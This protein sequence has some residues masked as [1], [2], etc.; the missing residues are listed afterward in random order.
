MTLPFAPRLTVTRPRELALRI[1]FD[2]QLEVPGPQPTSMVFMLYCHSEAAGAL[3][4]PEQLAFEPVVSPEHFTDFFGNRCARV[5]MSEPGILKV[6][7]DAIFR[8]PYEPEPQPDATTAQH[9]PGQ[10]PVNALPFLLGS[11]YCEIDRLSAIAWDLF[12]KLPPGG[13]RVLAIN[14]W[15]FRNIRFGYRH[16]RPNK[17]ALDT[18]VERTGVC[19]DMM[20]LAISFCRAMNIPARYAT[21]YLG[22]IEADPDPTPMD[23][24]AFYEVYLDGRWWPM[25][26][27]H[28]RARIGRVLMARGR[29]AADVALITSFGRHR[30]T[31]FHVLTDEL[32]PAVPKPAEPGAAELLRLSA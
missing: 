7:H 19:R 17:T 13:S 30:L 16:T 2:M 22:D 21:G 11:R 9:E 14:D 15:V 24:S 12:G 18:Y 6:S 10:L 3:D 32:T 31:K 27:R 29:D 25:D 4:F 23:F 26:A 20:H 8:C 5:V 1:G 28:G